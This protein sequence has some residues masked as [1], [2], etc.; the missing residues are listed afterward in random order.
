MQPA[1]QPSTSHDRLSLNFASGWKLVFNDTRK[2]GRAWLTDDPQSVL[3]AL[4]P[5][6]FDA[7]LTPQIFMPCC[8][9]ALAKL[10]PS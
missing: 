1:T 2:F 10:S 7:A 5:E 9:R 6:P 8:R 3:A 4:G